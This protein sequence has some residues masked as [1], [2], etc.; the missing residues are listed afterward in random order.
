MAEKRRMTISRFLLALLITVFLGLVWQIPYQIGNF[1][2]HQDQLTGD[3]LRGNTL[4]VR[5]DLEKLAYFYSWNDVLDNLWLD[6]LANKYLFYNA[7]Y[8]RS[9]LDYLTGNYTKTAKDLQDD[10]SFWAL[11]LKANTKWRLAQGMYQ[12]ALEVKD[13]KEAERIKKE[14]EELAISSKDEYEEAIRN[15][16]LHS[17]PPK[18]DYDLTNDP[19]ARLLALLPKP[20]V[21]IPQFGYPDPKGVPSSGKPGEGGTKDLEQRR[22]LPNPK[23]GG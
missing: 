13:K 5:E 6:G 9:A 4:A 23:K 12:H 3:V 20:K 19:D 2:Q 14:A 1:Y 17:F 7:P 21:K 11:Y 18:W 10:Q 22:G 16:P 15:D 8:Y